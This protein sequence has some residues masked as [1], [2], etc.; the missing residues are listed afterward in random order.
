MPAEI[1]E[2]LLDAVL[3]GGVPFD[4]ALP[5]MGGRVVSQWRCGGPSPV[6]ATASAEHARYVMST[7]QPTESITTTGSAALLWIG[8]DDRGVELRIVAAVLPDLYLVIHVMPTALR[9]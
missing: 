6:V 4:L 8:T 5:A 7:V 9:R 3:G 2:E 1:H